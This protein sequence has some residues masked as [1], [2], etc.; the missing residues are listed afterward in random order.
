MAYTLEQLYNELVDLS[1]KGDEAAA[2]ALLEKHFA[3]LPEDVQGK[4]LAQLYAGS[5][6]REAGQADEVLHL[7]E[8]GVLLIEALEVLK[9]HLK[10]GA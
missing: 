2:R 1:N 8:K 6:I 5:V 7:Q 10:T 9:S 4:V 3:G